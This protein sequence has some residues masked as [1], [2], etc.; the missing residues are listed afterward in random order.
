VAQIGVAAE[1]FIDATQC[2]TLLLSYV[3][4]LSFRHTAVQKNTETENTLSANFARFNLDVADY[5]FTSSANPNG[6]VVGQIVG[7]A[8]RVNWNGV[9]RARLCL[10]RSSHISDDGDLDLQQFTE[11][12]V[13]LVQNLDV[14]SD[15]TLDFTPLELAV[16]L[17][18]GTDG[19][20]LYCVQL[21]DI[22][23]GVAAQTYIPI[24]RQK[25]WRTAEYI[26]LD[27]SSLGLVYTLAACFLLLSLMAVTKLLL[28]LY[29]RLRLQHNEMIIQLWI[30]LFALL[31][32]VS[33]WVGII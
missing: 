10:S 5:S 14:G 3:S 15:A 20:V 8:L 16:E 17:A 12:D 7:D 9:R 19:R 4:A 24:V 2:T 25:E 28:V 6:A 31:F 33:K 18:T 27:S 1:R 30:V 29:M 21:T 23:Q 11:R 13:A 32:S 22:D 26:R